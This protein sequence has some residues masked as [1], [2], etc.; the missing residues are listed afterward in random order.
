MR[1]NSK[2]RLEPQNE[3]GN[4]LDVNRVSGASSKAYDGDSES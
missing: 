4:N 1:R 2:S 3:T